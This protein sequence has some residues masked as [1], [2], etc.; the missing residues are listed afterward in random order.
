MQVATTT[1]QISRGSLAVCPDVAKVF[2]VVALR[3]VSFRVR[4]YLDNTKIKATQFEYLLTF[5]VS[6]YGNM[7]GGGFPRGCVHWVLFDWS[8]IASR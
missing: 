4:L 5:Y 3:K 6:C 8:S 1:P 2:V 7:N